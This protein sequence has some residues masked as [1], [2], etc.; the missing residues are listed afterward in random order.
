VIDRYLLHHSR[1]LEMPL[2]HIHNPANKNPKLLLWFSSRGKAGPENWDEIVK[3]I[4]AGYDIVSFDFRGLG[5]TRMPY[6]AISED[7]PL[8]GQLDFDHAYVNPIS[9]V[10]ADYVYNS[11]LTGRPYL[12]QMIEDAEIAARFSRAKFNT[13]QLAVTAAGEAYTLARSIAETLPDIKLLT[14]PDAQILNWSEIVEQKR[15]LW[16]IQYLLPDG[17]YIH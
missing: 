17:A 2:L 7:D 15:E 1:T 12:L 14:Q 8:L 4:D 13:K 5:E 11:L 3:Y 6:K 16:P 10:L 9:G